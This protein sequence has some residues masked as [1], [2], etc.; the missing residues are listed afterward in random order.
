[1]KTYPQSIITLHQEL[2]QLK[3][4]HE[5]KLMELEQQ[6][7]NPKADSGSLEKMQKQKLVEFEQQNPDID[8]DQVIIIKPI[9]KAALY[10][11]HNTLWK[12]ANLKIV[13]FH[14]A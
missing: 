7:Q 14:L 11:Q 3:L 6:K 4:E 8:L 9:N 2:E 13:R 1:M 10:Y 5:Q 12:V